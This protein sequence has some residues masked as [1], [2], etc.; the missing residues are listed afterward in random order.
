MLRAGLI[1]YGYWGPNLARNFAAHPECKLT[2]IAD[3][4]EARRKQAAANFPSV[5]VVESGSITRD[6]DLDVIIIAT[7]VF[8]HFELAKEAL[9]NGK[10]VWLEKP[11]TSTLAQAQE[12][13]EAA[14]RNKR[15]LMVDHTFL[16]TGAVLKMKE[17]IDTGEL[18]GLYYYDSVR[19]NL[20]IFQ[21][22][23]NVV[24]DLAP[25]DLSIMDF[26]LGP[27]AEAISAHGRGHFDTGLEDVAYVTVFYP[28]NLI[29]HFHLNW[30][31]PVKL[32]RTVVG[33]SKKMLVWDDLNREEQIKIYNKGMDVTTKE[34]LYRILATPR[35]GD[36]YAPV[37]AA[38]EALK[39][40]VAYF[41]E[42]INSGKNP[43]NDAAAGAR[44]VGML[45]ATNQS[46]KQNG[47]VIPLK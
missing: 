13:V 14:E 19:I 8:T 40:E 20:G 12:L 22:D 7:P 1:G 18:G 46:L 34:G 32:R 45:E 6:S 17:L 15:L 25:H 21:H 9:E 27:K 10:H 26:L 47:R 2:R 37:V 39:A 35:H 3:M 41:V 43:H 30:L 33:G 11:M 36:M 23:V 28:G 5:E 29:A 44:I 38:S 4:S 24:W 42:C 31:S 16:F